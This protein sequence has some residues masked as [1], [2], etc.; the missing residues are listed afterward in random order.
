MIWS[1]YNYLYQSLK[2]G[3]LLYNSRTNAFMQ[4]DGE[5]Y[6]ILKQISSGAESSHRVLLYDDIYNTLIRN[7]IL[8]NEYEDENYITQMKYR[9]Y[10]S[11][12]NNN[13][14]GLV[15]APTT[16]CNFMCPYCYEHN[17]QT[18]KMNS[19]VEEGIVSFIKSFTDIKGVNIC[20]HGGEPLLAID[21]IK[22]ILN[23][24]EKEKI[25]ILKHS[26]VTNGFLFD[27]SVCEMFNKYKLSNIQITLDGIKET[28]NKSRIHKSG[29]ETFDIIINNINT[30]LRLMPNT[31][32]TIRMNI[33]ENNKDDAYELYSFLSQKWKNQNVR[34]S[35]VFAND[36]EDCKV[37]CLKGSERLDYALD[38][39]EKYNF[40]KIRLYPKANNQLNCTAISNN[41]FIIG[42][43]GELYKCWTDLGKKE[44]IIGNIYS[45][46]LNIGLLSEYVLNSTKFSDNVCLKCGLFPVCD[47]GCAMQRVNNK[48]SMINNG[49]CPINTEDLP[50]L[51]DSVYMQLQNKDV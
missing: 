7:K 9:Y 23:T 22:A 8:V 31:L 48:V 6:N 34:I 43:E 40:D 28:H 39:Y 36:C 33:H 25:N 46:E 19:K 37:G 47:G 18:L 13:Y 16:A 15:I 27:S 5:L 35:L 3:Y 29:I 11:A 21:N 51:L 41:S 32:V 42:P 20:W 45:K 14:L 17:L 30:I 24:C 44:K 4:L 10:L 1:R 50:K 2:F 38:L 26:I 49:I 12:F